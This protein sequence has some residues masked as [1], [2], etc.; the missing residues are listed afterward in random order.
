MYSFL[1]QVGQS[2]EPRQSDR[3][4]SNH[5]DNFDGGLVCLGINEVELTS[6]N[7]IGFMQRLTAH[8]LHV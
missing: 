7:Y 1:N 4:E 6:T 3:I 2:L 5:V 8:T